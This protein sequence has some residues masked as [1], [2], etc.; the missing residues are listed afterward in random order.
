M[1][2]GAIPSSASRARPRGSIVSPWRN[3]SSAP[4]RPAIAAAA[5][6]S[7]ASILSTARSRSR[8]VWLI[9]EPCCAAWSA[10][11]NAIPAA[12]SAATG[13]AVQVELAPVLRERVPQCRRRMRPE[14][15]GVKIDLR[16]AAPPLAR[17]RELR[18]RLEAEADEHAL[19]RL[20]RR[21][22]NEEVAV[23]VPTL[24][25]PVEAARNR[26]PTQEQRVDALVGKR[27]EHLRRGEVGAE[28]HQEPHGAACGSTGRHYLSWKRSSRGYGKK[29][30]IS[31]ASIRRWQS[32]QNSGS[33]RSAWWRRNGSRQP[34]VAEQERWR[35]P[36]G[37]RRGE[38]RVPRLARELGLGVRRRRDA[39]EGDVGQVL[40]LVVVVEDDAAVP[41]D[42][43]VPPEQV[44]G[45]DV[46][47]GEVADRVAVLDARRRSSSSGVARSR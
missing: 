4:A 25:L 46:R 34:R 35:T 2:D 41:G 1:T 18:R 8:R 9:E 7:P 38:R 6:Q 16:V 30:T 10:T 36:P 11:T 37:R 19:E 15:P 39:A 32:C 45:E 3:A 23:G 29:S 26:R 21:L 27:G 14:Q 5:A 43:E 33:S 12:S 20:P 47:D 13:R 31:P 28:R 42:A 17:V 40:E 22:G 44:A 24:A